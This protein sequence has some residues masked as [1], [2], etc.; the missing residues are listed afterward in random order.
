MGE[1]NMIGS[2]SFAPLLE[3]FFLRRLM[4]QRQASPHTIASYRDTFCQLLAFTK[5]RLHK[6]P[7]QLLFENIAA[8]LISRF[9][10]HLEK[11]D[12]IS[13]RTRNLRLT[14]IHSF[15]RYAAFEV[16]E[17]AAQIQRVLAIPSKRFTRT[18]VNFLTRA[19]VDA[20][21]AAPD[22]RTW[23][24]RRDHAFMLTAVQTGFRLSEM[25]GLK[26]EDL[27]LGVGAHLRVIGQGR[28]ERCTP[29]ARA[30]RAVLK[31]WLRE[32]QRGN[33]KLLFPS[34]RG[35]R[36][37]VH[38]VQYLL[39]KHRLVAC[40]ACASLKEKRVSVHRLRHTMAM[41]LLQEGVD[42]STIALWL[43]HQHEATT[44]TYLHA[45]LA[46][47]EKALATL[48]PRNGKPSRYRPDDRLLAFLKNL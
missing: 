30:T 23:S 25:T 8:P 20:L 38:G 13:I 44:Q 21:L 7:S 22:R 32:P 36:L 14:A 42:R 3:R 11:N 34:A 41:D 15:F 35:E 5:E 29:L 26:R 31:A 27:I 37:S 6:S 1:A 33:S 16:P 9:L 18:V 10:D 24:S 2:A 46:M 28:R 17:H 19:E 47:K 40:K 39:N 43:G 12:G 4:Q 48:A 45:T